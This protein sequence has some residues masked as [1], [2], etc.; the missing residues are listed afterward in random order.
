MRHRTGCYYIYEA[1]HLD[2]DVHILAQFEENRVSLISLKTGNR[3]QCP[4][5][6]HTHTCLT[7]KEWKACSDGDDFVQIAETWEGL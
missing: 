1:S 4:I 2:N 3:W 6:V 7:D 5:T